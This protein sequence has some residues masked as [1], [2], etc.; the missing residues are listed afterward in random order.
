M[1]FSYYTKRGAFRFGIKSPKMELETKEHIIQLIIRHVQGTLDDTG[2][3]EL[4]EWRKVSSEN[5]ALFLKMTSRVYFEESLKACEMTNEEMENEWKLIHGKTIGRRRGVLK[6]LLRYAAILIAFIVVGSIWMLE[7]K[8]SK[9]SD[10]SLV[11]KAH[12]VKKIEPRAIL[13]MGDGT[14]INLKDSAAL[15]ALVSMKMAFSADE[16]VLTYTEGHMHSVVEYHTMKIPRGG[17]YV[18]VLSDGTTVYL[19]AES[20]LTYPVKFSENDRRVFLKG[21]AYFDVQRDT[22]KPFVVEANSLE[23]RVLGTEFGVRAYQNEGSIRTTLKK[24]MV[25]V[26]NE[27]NKVVLTPGMQASFN[28]ETAKMDVWEVNVDLFLAWKDGRLVFDNCSLE[29]ILEDLGKWYDFNIRYAREDARLIPFSL[30]IK[31]HNAFA[32]VLQLFE[33]T[34][35]VEFNIE[36]NVVIVK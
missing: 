28:K 34:G 35:C 4:L 12:Q 20:E 27:E 16:D 7:I 11:S 14:T 29:N 17:E 13:V 15:A 24:G 6:N 2:Q 25:S 5:E 23:I 36:D 10:N 9:F 21:E 33:E 18:L 8:N 31:K 26:E 19:N 22:S 3:K 1:A 30:N 32:E